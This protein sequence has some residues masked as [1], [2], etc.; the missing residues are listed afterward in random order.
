M[1]ASGRTTD[2]AVDA[3]LKMIR[4]HIDFDRRHQ[5]QPLSGFVPAPRIYRDAFEKGQQRWIFHDMPPLSRNARTL[6][7]VAVVQQNPA[8]RPFDTMARTA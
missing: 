1:M 5:R 2:L 4:A 3:L 6:V 7:A 8:I